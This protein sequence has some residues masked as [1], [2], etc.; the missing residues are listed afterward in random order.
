MELTLAQM[1]QKAIEAQ[2]AG[3]LQEARQLY[4]SILQAHSTHPSANFNMGTLAVGLNKLDEALPFFKTAYESRPSNVQF[5]R[6]YV[7]ALV[8]LGHVDT[9]KAV[10][11]HAKASGAQGEELD[12]LEKQL[13]E[14]KSPQSSESTIESLSAAKSSENS[15]PPQ[16]L[17][18]PLINLHS[19]GQLQQALDQATQMLHQFPRSII[20][21]NIQGVT[22]AGLGQFDT[23]IDCFK[24]T[25]TLK[26]NYVE[27]YNNMGNAQKANG[28]LGAAIESYKQ[29]IIIKPDYAEAH[30]NMGNVLKDKSDLEAAVESYKRAIK[31][32]PDYAEAHS[33]MGNAL[34]DKGDLEAAVESYKHAIE[35][36]SDYL[37]AFYNMGIALQEKGD[38][39]A[40]IDSYKQAI[41]IKPDYAEAYYN[42][43]D[44]LVE[45]GDRE[46]AVES[47]KHAIKI[48]PD[49]AE[50]FYNMGISL[51]DNGDL[52]AAIDSYKQA[53]KIKPDYAEAYNNMGS[54]LQEKGDLEA[55]IDSYK[56]AI[57]I[58]PDYA[59]AYNNRGN[60]LKD[61]GELEAAI[62]SC[63]KAIKIKPDYAEAYLNMGNALQE[64][65]DLEAA[66]DSYKHSI[67]IKPDYAEAFYNMGI[68]L[69]EQGDLDAAIDSYKQ[70]IKIKP[71]YA[72]AHNN[73]GSA[74]VEKNDLKAAMH[75]YKQAL[76]INPDYQATRSLKLHQQAH[77]CDWAG[78]EEDQ[79][80][81]PALGTSTQHISPFDLLALEDAPDRHRLRSAIFAKNTFKQK[82]LPLAPK[83]SQK[84]DRLRIGYFSADFREHTISYLLVR[85]L[86][87]HNPE[88]F[89]IYAYSFGPE[90][91][92]E[93][94]QRIKSAVDV[95][96][97]VTKMNDRDI[98][99]LARQ[100]KID[101][102]IDLTGYTQGGRTGIFAYRAAPIQISYLGHGGT[103]GADFIDYII[104]DPIVI[105]RTHE[106]HYNEKIIRVPNAYQPNDNTREL[107]KKPM[108]RSEAGLPDQGF[109]FCCFNN[110]Y[111]IM[112][113]EFDIWMRL[114]LKVEG[115]VLWMRNS[116]ELS[117]VN[118]RKEA[119]KRGVDAFRIIFAEG[120]PMDEHLARHKLADLFVDTFYFN[121]H[122]TAS[123]ALW[124]GL[125][126]VS[127]LGEG[128]PARVAGSFLTAI[129][130]PELITKT[131]DDYEA[132]ILDL[133]LNPDRLNA[134]RDKLNR[135]RLTAPLFNTELVT[136]HLEEGYQQAY[137]RY[138]DGKEPEN[139]DVSA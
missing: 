118:L 112:P 10:F 113:T 117:V 50:A 91:T 53:I 47:Y 6:Y 37:G 121:A 89:E 33:N 67:K 54:V 26:S 56:Q 136:K 101:I 104:A 69:K 17:L 43:A 45:K 3:Q 46:A 103:M 74:L 16:I 66:I 84:P 2:K 72:E 122:T 55:A 110:N 75:S 38:L 107:S 116:N 52:E 48:K 51:E 15:E 40:A 27:A 13:S 29:A 99:L 106:Q 81:I 96:V 14:L 8:K 57:K 85:A 114:L 28:D 5:V 129:G 87:L 11:S 78:I 123:D 49:Y 23:A 108:S 135:N 131:K 30:S 19:Q 88:R 36:K 80:L 39:E 22:N 20:L 98:V 60:A 42:M 21:H 64:K 68:A 61:K 4:V 65:D 128:L 83:P 18:Q 76:K 133:A 62:D 9:A 70:A 32:K 41:K 105:P 71:D 58:K 7:V 100:D 137:Q 124:A 44:A 35:I 132:L 73:M 115:S 92:G 109:V 120:V 77:I 130:L 139:I 82:P 127:K 138:F 12:L 97:D 93:M 25:L 24:K 31:I 95:F 86:E 126:V 34:K 63:K 90:G 59:E 94:Q 79:H 102:A 119:E 111:K 134:I 1:L 125:P